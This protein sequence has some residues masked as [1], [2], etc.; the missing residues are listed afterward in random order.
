MDLLFGLQ[1]L[2]KNL[3]DED[4]NMFR[5]QEAR[6]LHNLHRA[7]L[8][9]HT[10]DNRREQEAILDDLD[11]LAR[12][13]GGRDFRELCRGAT[14]T[15]ATSSSMTTIH[16]QLEPSQQK[17]KPAEP[18][19][20]KVTVDLLTRSI[21]TAL[22]YQQEKHDF[23][24]LKFTI[25][26]TFPDCD[27][28]RLLIRT[29]I[30]DYSYNEAHSVDI[31]KGEKKTFPLLPILKPS[32]LES[33]YEM[34]PAALQINIEFLAPKQSKQEQTEH[35]RLHA[36]NTAILAVQDKDG[37]QKD[38]TD[39]L[40]AW[41][42]PRHPAIQKL[43]H[44]AARSLGEFIGYP[45]ADSLAESARIVRE[46]AKAIFDV[47]YATGFV[48]VHSSPPV[49]ELDG[50]LL[51]MVQLPADV[52]A[53]GGSGNCLDGA[54]IF[55]SMLERISLEPLIVLSSGHA[56]VGWRI[57][58]G[59]EQFEFLETTLIGEGD[60]ARAQ[61]VA[62]ERFH[63]MKSEGYFTKK[64]LDLFGFACLIDI[65]QCRQQGILPF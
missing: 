45:R 21:P 31:A 27:L 11:Q 49:E 25:D 14:G 59:E 50:Q 47:L 26:N 46:Q 54:L 43:V 58:A 29:F 5:E 36:R 24:L 22:C 30:E 34:R 63:Q 20:P 57:A 2:K 15:T 40:A 7:R 12:S 61:H 9:G 55:A 32:A 52:L 28:A 65:A 13:Y 38:F 6:M 35:I 18:D 42:T 1:A 41:V 19:L 48:Y 4:K 8:Y 16:Q 17:N 44:Q 39:Y 33:L 53:S 23:P 56:F 51:Q 64:F 3:L 37:N 60:F 10:E 62:Q